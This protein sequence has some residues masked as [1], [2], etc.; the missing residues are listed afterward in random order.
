MVAAAA[1]VV[2]ER[3]A[4]ARQVAPP[5]RPTSYDLAALDAYRRAADDAIGEDLALLSTAHAQLGALG[6]PMF[7]VVAAATAGEAIELLGQQL[8][9]R[10]VLGMQVR[11]LPV[12]DELVEVRLDTD[13]GDEASARVEE[14]VITTVHHHLQLLAGPIRPYAVNLRRQAPAG[15]TDPWRA[16]FGVRPRFGQRVTSMRVTANSLATPMLTANPDLRAVLAAPTVSVATQVGAHVRAHLTEDLSVSTIAAA[17]GLTPRSLQ[18]RLSEEGQVLRD[19]VTAT[20]IEA[21]RDLLVQSTAPIASIA[22]AVGFRQTSSFSR[23]FAA[24]TGQTAQAYRKE[25]T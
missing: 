5:A 10:M 16:F 14:V 13:H 25:R 24:H 22:S 12:E 8:L 17:L 18:R 9:R 7:G 2:V 1:I 21:A 6:L 20:R 3:C 15:S 19:L 11:L 4:A 23:A